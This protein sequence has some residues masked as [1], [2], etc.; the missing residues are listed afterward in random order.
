VVDVSIMMPLSIVYM[1]DMLSD[2]EIATAMTTIM[3]GDDGGETT[4]MIRE[5]D[6]VLLS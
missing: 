4:T 3:I 2:V 5:I 1:I 6:E